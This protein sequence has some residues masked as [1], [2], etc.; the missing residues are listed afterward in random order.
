MRPVNTV[1]NKR[2][3]PASSFHRFTRKASL[4][5]Q[6]PSTRTVSLASW[7]WPRLPDVSQWQGQRAWMQWVSKVHESVI[8]K[9]EQRWGGLWTALHTATEDPRRERSAAKGQRS[10][11]SQWH[12]WARRPAAGWLA[13]PGCSF[14][15]NTEKCLRRNPGEKSCQMSWRENKIEIFM[16]I[17]KD[18]PE[19]LQV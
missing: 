8:Y 2:S 6:S 3:P 4:V 5:I 14:R 15:L 7:C 11:W 12:H 10:G 19:K 1:E 17:W 16:L 9:S 13:P 18:S